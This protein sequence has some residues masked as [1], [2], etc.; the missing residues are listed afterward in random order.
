MMIYKKSIS[1]KIRTEFFLR[2]KYI[3]QIDDNFIIVLHSWVFEYMD[4]KIKL[5]D[6]QTLEKFC[7]NDYGHLNIIFIH[8]D[9]KF[10]N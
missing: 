2:R 10:Y 6:D 4:K 9:I 3:R 1:K 7:V 5:H 8:K